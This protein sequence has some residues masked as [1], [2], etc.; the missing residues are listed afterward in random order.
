MTTQYSEIRSIN[1]ETA[2]LLNA[3]LSFRSQPAARGHEHIATK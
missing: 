1:N 3:E 2:Y